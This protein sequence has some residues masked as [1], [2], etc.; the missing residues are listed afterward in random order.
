[1][2]AA[3]RV[4]KHEDGL[5]AAQAARLVLTGGEEGEGAAEFKKR[6]RPAG[7]KPRKVGKQGHGD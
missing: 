6:K 2:D 5:G 4:V 3:D 7:V 1:M